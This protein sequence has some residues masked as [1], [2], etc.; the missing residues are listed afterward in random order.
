[1]LLRRRLSDF[2]ARG[3]SASDRAAISRL[4]RDRRNRTRPRLCIAGVD[5][6]PLVPGSPRHGD[7]HGDHGLRRRRDDCRAFVG[8]PD[9]PFPQRNEH[10]RGRDVHRARHCVFHLDVDRCARDPRAARRLEAGRLDAARS[11]AEEDDF[12]QP[13]AYRSGVED[14][15]VLSD[16]AR[17]VP[18]R[19]GRH[20]HSRPGF[21]DDRGR[22]SRTR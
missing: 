22:A 16:L 7:R 19:D 14:A 13:R 12:A 6:D 5:A 3:V 11:P 18:E 15:A 20:R 2:R 21:G 10:R 8:G 1:M 9:E 4:W 17:A